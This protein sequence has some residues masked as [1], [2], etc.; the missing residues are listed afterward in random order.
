MPETRFLYMKTYLLK[1]RS[2][3]FGY[4]LD[5]MGGDCIVVLCH[6]HHN[7]VHK[8]LIDLLKV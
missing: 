8:G 5:I 3:G 7:D 4:G 6:K 2:K 1:N